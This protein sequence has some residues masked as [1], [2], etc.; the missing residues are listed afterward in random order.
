MNGQRRNGVSAGM[1]ER[2]IGPAMGRKGGAC[3]ETDGE[4]RVKLSLSDEGT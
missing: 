3:T 1:R 4:G 2:L